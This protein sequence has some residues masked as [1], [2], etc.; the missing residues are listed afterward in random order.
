M[1]D[2]PVQDHTIPIKNISVYYRTAG[3]PSHQA[4]ILLN[5]WGARVWSFPFNSERVIGE[6]A[7]RG[8]YV[9]SP[10]HPGLMRS[11]TP[12]TV[13]GFR[14]YAE[15]LDEFIA[16]LNIQNPIIIG[17]S[18][19]GAVATAYAAE[20]WEL[21]KTLV[22]VC[23]GLSDNRRLHLFS[24][25]KLYGPNFLWLVTKPYVPR[26]FKK[27][28]VASALGVP[29]EQAGKEPWER[30]AIMSKIFANWFLP[31]VYPKIKV[32]TILIWGNNDLLFPLSMAKEVTKKLPHGE[33]YTVF[34]GHSVLYFRPKEIVSLIAGKL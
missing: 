3:G 19:G 20:H 24:R 6:F 17:Q 22:L 30:R 33:L 18:F 34:G 25:L 4:I 5:G 23:S 28:L 26:F 32:R 9:I 21:I 13:W 12:K 16:K 31:D 10:E 7:R 14:E 8:F 29:W 15:Y 2:I 27:C 11:E 1:N